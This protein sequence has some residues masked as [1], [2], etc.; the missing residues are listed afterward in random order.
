MTD[1]LLRAGELS[2]RRFIAQAA[3]S[4]LG[5]GLLPE[6]FGSRTLAAEA[7]AKLLRPATAKNVIYLF[8]G[9]GQSH[10]DTWDP[11]EGV[12]AAGPTKII[13]TSADGTR[14]SEH[15]PR[16]AKQMHRATVVRSLVSTQG[17]HEQGV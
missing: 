11:K 4:L 15:L 1:L 8:M 12:V 17:A 16:S 9:G 13:K 5:V 6:I 7:P 3:S 2:R 10:L 14:I